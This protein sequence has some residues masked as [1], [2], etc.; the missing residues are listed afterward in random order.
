MIY[1]IGCDIIAIDRIKK[2]FEKSKD[3]FLKKVFTDQEIEKAPALES[4]QYHAY[5]AK[6]FAAKESYAKATRLGIRANISF[7]SIEIL[8]DLNNA[9]Y[10]NHHPLASKNIKTFLS[11]SDEANFAVAYVILTKS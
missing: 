11:L 1:G 7:R 2:I 9:P 5:F 10:F 3:R 8:N 6:R 4:P